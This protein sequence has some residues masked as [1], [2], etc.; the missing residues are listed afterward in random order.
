[1]TRIATMM[2]V[3]A[4]AGCGEGESE[5]DPS[6]DCCDASTD[7][8]FC[9]EEGCPEGT[10]DDG[11]GECCDDPDADGECGLTCEEG[12]IPN[13]DGTACCDDSD[14]DDACD[15]DPCPEGS[16]FDWV[17]GEC[18]DD[19]DGDDVC[20]TPSGYV[21]PA[22]I[23]ANAAF[24]I[25]PANDHDSDPSTPVRKMV[26][27]H[28]G[29]VNGSVAYINANTYYT[30]YDSND[31]PICA[32]MIVHDTQ[33]VSETEVGGEATPIGFV[34]DTSQ[35]NVTVLD[36]ADFGEVSCFNEDGT[37]KLAPEVWGVN[38][39]DSIKDAGL[40]H[41]FAVFGALPEGGLIDTVLAGAIPTYETDYAPYILSA[42]PIFSGE[43]IRRSTVD[44][45]TPIALAF[46]RAYSVTAAYDAGNL[47]AP[48]F[49][50]SGSALNSRAGYFLQSF[51]FPFNY[52]HAHQLVGDLAN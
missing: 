49:L 39:P 13:P 43:V 30:F 45:P 15:P 51:S 18:C 8:G 27:D 11:T 5:C 47:A 37:Q 35:P 46:G 44:D 17:Y 42:T 9:A 4:L 50:S 29:S 14:A 21:G 19:A 7:D 40:S 24:A 38:F 3:L 41:G 10:V 2:V 52:S 48:N 33:V 20:D 31:D 1:M 25:D 34:M 28:F 22:R 26:R 6:V 23:A 32:F 12:T 36:G 16:T